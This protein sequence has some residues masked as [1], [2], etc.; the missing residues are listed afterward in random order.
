MRICQID[1]NF[2]HQ[3]NDGTLGALA[4]AKALGFDH[5]LLA[6][7]SP[8]HTPPE[9]LAAMAAHCRAQGLGC[10]LELALDRY[11]DGAAP[12]DPGWRHDGAMPDPRDTDNHLPGA[13]LR[14]HDEG[15]AAALVSW[16]TER[17]QGL[18]ELDIAGY[19]CRA[20][21][22]VA[23]RHWGRLIAALKGAGACG[24]HGEARR[25]PLMLAWTPGTSPAQLAD[26]AG[27]GSGAGFDGAFCSLPWWDYRSPWLAEEIA[28]LRPFGAVL[29]APAM[30]AR[31]LDALAARRALWTAAALGDGI[32]VPAGFE[33]GGGDCDDDP[34]RDQARDQGRGQAADQSRDRH[35]GRDGDA[36]PE[37]SYDLS[38]ELIHANAWIAARGPAPALAVRQLS[39]ADGALVALARL[40]MPAAGAPLPLAIV[41]NPDLQQPASLGADRILSALPHGAGTLL[42]A[43]GGPGGGVEPGT[44]LDALDNITLAPAG[45]QLFHAAP[46]AALAEPARREG[47]RFGASVRAALERSVAAAVQAPRIAIENVA[48]ACDNGR[49]AVR[50][51]TGERVEVS[52]DI[53]MDGHDKLAAVV[54]W[55]GPGE[56]SWHE[57]PMV[58]TVNDRW[59]GSFALTA[60]GRHE[61]T[62]EAWHDAFATWCDEVT[63]KKQ[64]GVDVTLEIEEG[65]RLVANTLRHGRTG[66]REA[67]RALREVVAELEAAAKD[68]LRRLE[69]LLSPHTRTLMQAADPR[70]FSTRHPVAMPVEADR[71]AARFA[72][73]YELF[74]R[75]QSGDAE[76]HGTFDDVIERLP[77]IRAMGFDV[78]YFPPIHPI[79]RANRKGRNNSLR[80]APDDPGSPYA[81]GS[82]EGG[83]DAI[84]PQLGT[85]EDFR[86]LRA[87]SAAAGLELALD[88]AIQCSP[89]HPWLREHPEWFAHRPDGSLRYAENPPK[90]YEDIVNVDFYAK[91]GAAPAL[92]IALRDVVM[93]WVNEGVR[94]FRVDNPHTKPLPFWEWMIANVRERHPDTIFLA[95]AF[96]RPKMMARLAKLGFSQSYTYFTW[97]NHKREL[98]EYM[99]ELTR[100]PLR[101]YFRPHFFV[102]T[103][104]INPYFL[105]DSGRPGFLIRAAL[106]TLLSGLWGMYNGFEL[107]EGTPL[108]V[109]GVTKEEYLDSEKYQ[110]RAWDW[111]RPGNIVAEITRLNQ[112]RASHPALQNHLGLRFLHASDDAVLYFARYVPTSHDADAAFGD[113]VLLVAINLDPRTVREADIELPLWEWG[114]P[115]HGALAAEDLMHGHRFQWQG[116]HQ[117]IRLDP[118]ALPFAL[119]HVKPR[120]EES[121]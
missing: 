6:G 100:T 8:L 101:E 88:F 12:I 112:I 46:S 18:A 10:L 53:W 50:R 31:G 120:R 58:P 33:C 49:F 29:A 27:G 19:V 102:N 98:I 71:L 55:R 114:L 86:R 75:S 40:P 68:D 48:P 76:R 54:L 65:A 62:V 92:W 90:K 28:R 11:P 69:I 104:D 4:R 38:H 118:H 113:D 43:D 95:E 21:A 87:A 73:W 25:P 84:H 99:T 45:V 108:V 15:V 91:G 93:F 79:G 61:F 24:K 97:R 77:A 85:I 67:S 119:W 103:P 57:A 60:L 64:A 7:A 3:A 23:G 78:L 106:A 74:P 56:E 109:N 121:A 34:P 80:A 1:P 72:S 89:D 117:R 105:H 70:H 116:K 96:T 44:L 107:C 51:V 63:K 83:H 20:P 41:I 36:D 81:I 94:I 26:L 14:W 59:V 47:K 30:Q 37:L 16:W 5:V 82:A 110:L 52:A 39:G 66:E 17:L 42:A 22:R 9:T 111:N 32:L 35:G 13:R 115:D 2:V